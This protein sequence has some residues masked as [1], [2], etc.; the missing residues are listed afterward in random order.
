MTDR[1]VNGDHPDLS[2]IPDDLTN[3]KSEQTDKKPKDNPESAPES[4]DKQ[5]E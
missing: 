1:P 5:P 4:G 3:D 2:P